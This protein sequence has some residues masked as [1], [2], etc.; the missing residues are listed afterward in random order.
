MEQ[1]RYFIVYVLR[2][3]AAPATN[4]ISEVTMKQVRSATVELNDLVFSGRNKSYGAYQLRAMYK[5]N[6]TFAVVTGSVAFV[7]LVSF[8]LVRA[9]FSPDPLSAVPI[10][11][12][13]VVT[14][15][16]TALPTPSVAV[17]PEVQVPRKATLKFTPPVVL[18]DNKVN[19]DY[20][21]TQDE[22]TKADPGKV[23]VKGDPGALNVVETDPPLLP[24][25]V[26]TIQEDVPFFAVENMPAFPGGDAELMAYMVSN[27]KY[28]ALAIRGGVEGKVYVAF[29]VEKD[30][31]ITG[32]SVVK[33]IGGGCD[34]EALRVLKAMPA[35]NPGRQNGNAVRV[36]I[37]VPVVFRLRS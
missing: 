27:L 5:R 19:D 30:G 33:G 32:A 28:P 21:P 7:V 14:L 25:P 8:P 13:T 9:M 26:K 4:I 24:E 18:P 37:T 15:A 12:N 31:S 2:A 11:A 1:F 17:P 6:L 35:W 34:E 16:Y 22:L 10:G 3:N 20:I 36:K 29:V 23:T